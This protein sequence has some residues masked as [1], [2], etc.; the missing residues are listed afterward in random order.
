[1]KNRLLAGML[2]TALAVQTAMPF[3]MGMVYAEEKENIAVE[4]EE[5]EM[6]GV[7]SGECGNNVTYT[8]DSNGLLTIKPK[9]NRIMA[10]INTE[11]FLGRTDIKKVKIESGIENIP[12]GTFANC[13]NITNVEFSNDLEEIEFCAFS[14]CSNLESINIPASATIIQEFAFRDC[15]RLKKITFSGTSA[16]LGSGLFLSNGVFY[17]CTSLEKVTLPSNLTELGYGVFFN[18]HLKSVSVAEGNPAYDSRNNCNAVIRKSDDALV[19]GCMGTTQIPDGVVRVTYDAFRGFDLSAA[20]ITIPDSVGALEAETETKYGDWIFLREIP[21][22]SEIDVN[23]LL[24]SNAL[25]HFGTIYC[26]SDSDVY[27]L[28]DYSDINFILLDNNTKPNNNKNSNSNKDNNNNNNNKKMPSSNTVEKGDNFLLNGY[29]YTVKN[30]S[31]VIFTGVN[32]KISKVKKISIPATVKIQNKKYKVTAM[33][34][35]SLKGVQAE[36]IVIGDNVKTIGTSA[37]ENCKK[38]T[39]V[40][41]GKNVNKIGKYAFKSDKKLKTV[42]I[43]SKKLKSVGK[44]AFKGIHSN[45][46]MK[47]PS[48][49]KSAYKKLMKGAGL[50]KKVK[51]VKG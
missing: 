44:N 6:N 22:S 25:F 2:I 42:T 30:T 50:G 48:N 20:S 24:R 17:G 36:T 19:L 11:S 47:V 16:N 4:N 13:S 8:L 27:V 12:K 46:K 35:K 39:S 15:K 5:T 34:D 37:M 41:L 21:N 43:K 31:E 51:I 32:G 38:L 33:S 9:T 49:K 23:Q 1:M 29:Y 18:T 26:R 40:T 14:G 7:E 10:R 28:K 45:A 3:E